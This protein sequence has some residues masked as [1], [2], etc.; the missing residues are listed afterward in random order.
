MRRNTTTKIMTR[1]MTTANVTTTAITVVLLS[2]EKRARGVAF[3]Q[4]Q[5]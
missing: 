1:Q 3:V 2:E 5:A 4:V